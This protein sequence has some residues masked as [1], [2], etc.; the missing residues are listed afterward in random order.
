M[1]SAFQTHEREAIRHALL[2]AARH[3]AGTIGMKKTTLDALTRAAGISK[4]AFYAFYPS[5]EH[6]FLEVHRQWH[7]EMYDTA[8]RALMAHKALPPRE[9]ATT[10]LIEICH[11]IAQSDML[12]FLDEDTHSLVRKLP[13]QMH[14]AS[15]Q[16]DETIMRA[17]LSQSDIHLSVPVEVAY[18]AVRI[19]F[20]SLPQRVVIG[21]QYDRAFALLL[22]ATCQEIIV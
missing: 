18:A 21:A 1:P 14:A 5:K 8:A 11:R 4:S 15:T 20:I 19:L 12:P 13:T 2:K 7:E 17:L 16:A 22:H 6:L 3:A 10:V 9:R